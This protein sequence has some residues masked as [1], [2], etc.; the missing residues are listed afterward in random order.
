MDAATIFDYGNARSY[1]KDKWQAMKRQNRKYSARF[2]SKELGFSNPV[3]FLR[4]INGDRALS[5]AIID[6]LVRIL[7]LGP[8]ESEYF[9]YLCYYTEETDP[10][11]KEDL[12]DKLISLNHTT[13]RFLLQ[14]EFKFHQNWYHNTVWVMLDVV[15]CDGSM[16]ACQSLG[17]KIFPR[18]PGAKVRESLDVLEGLKFIERDAKKNWRP[19]GKTLFSNAKLHDEIVMQYWLK[20]LKLAGQAIMGKPK[21]PPRVYTNTFS[22]S[23][24]ALVK[25]GKRLDAVCA[26][27]RAIVTKDEASTRVIHFQFQMIDQLQD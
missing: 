20:T 3:Y 22:C 9:R 21:T 12:L 11:R 7:K 26:E 24:R 25:I 8:E 6:P 15:D 13:Q 23:D 1:L 27:I 5:E 10:V 2:I 16:E 14:S 18:V 19:K 4:I 17:A